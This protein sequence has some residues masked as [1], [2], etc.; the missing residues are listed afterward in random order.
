MD[1][2]YEV[3]FVYPYTVVRRTIW[4]PETDEDKVLDIAITEI[5]NETGLDVSG[6]D[7]MVELTETLV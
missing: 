1:Y 6:A 4:T 5:A 7:A 3:T 2:E